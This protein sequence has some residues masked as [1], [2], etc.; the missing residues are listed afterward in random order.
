MSPQR[1]FLHFEMELQLLFTCRSFV[2][3]VEDK[4]SEK[5]VLKYEYVEA[6]W[7][8]ISRFFPKS[9]EEVRSWWYFDTT[10]S[11]SQRGLCQRCSIT[12][13]RIEVVEHLPTMELQV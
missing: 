11:S 10:V 7:M 8:K 9:L 12:Y 1:L 3:F 6:V 5:C 4:E 2:D 13:K